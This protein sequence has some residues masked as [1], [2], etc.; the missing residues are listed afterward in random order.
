[1]LKDFVNTHRSFKKKG[2][3][4]ANQLTFNILINPTQF[5]VLCTTPFDVSSFLSKRAMYDFKCYLFGADG[6]DVDSTLKFAS[7]KNP[8]HFQTIYLILLVQIKCKL[9]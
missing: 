7:G 5:G 4:C 1:M 2:E 9:T 3:C 8:P 6:M